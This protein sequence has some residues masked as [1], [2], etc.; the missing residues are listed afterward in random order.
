[1]YR[2][3]TKL[4]CRASFAGRY[5]PLSITFPCL[6]CATHTGTGLDVHPN[7]H[8]GSATNNLGLLVVLLGHA[9]GVNVLTK[10]QRVSVEEREDG[11]YVVQL[12]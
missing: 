5:A 12:N 6:T 9:A 3:H 2:Y 4:A 1:M 10:P 8:G 11:L 7:Q